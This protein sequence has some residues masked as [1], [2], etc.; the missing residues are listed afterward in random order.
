M[1]LLSVGLLCLC[2]EG[3]GWAGHG[4]GQPSQQILVAHGEGIWGLYG[5]VS[6]PVYETYYTTVA[7]KVPTTVT[8]RVQENGRALD[9]EVTEYKTV[10]KQVPATKMRLVFE[11]FVRKVNAETLEAFETDGRAIPVADLK[12]R[13]QGKALVVAA[14]EK[15][16]DYHAALFKPGTII[17]KVAPEPVMP[18]APHA[19]PAPAPPSERP[20]AIL[21]L[22]LTLPVRTVSFQPD[23]VPVEPP[24][25]PLTPEP[26]VVFASRDGADA[27]K[28]RRFRETKVTTDVTVRTG[29]SA[30][31]PEKLVKAEH[32]TR[33][34]ET[35][36]VPWTAVR[37]SQPDAIDLAINR[38]QERL[39]TAETPVLLSSDGKLVDSFWLQNIKPGVLVFRGVQFPQGHGYAAP[40]AYPAPAPAPTSPPAQAPPAPPST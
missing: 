2:W 24:Q 19:I 28:I 3:V 25:F 10:E 13:V 7:I 15:L 36:S 35:S 26:V 21:P 12:R 17:L 5:Q 38:V 6:K 20:Q 9:K 4:V 22:D 39:G 1:R 30:V 40:V 8:V 11:Q 32:I 31:A 37:V 33:H 29:D 23:A 27:V 34:S 16:P 18:P 14:P